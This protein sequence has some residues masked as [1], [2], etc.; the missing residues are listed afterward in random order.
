M[1][2]PWP[3]IARAAG[4]FAGTNVDDLVIL[5]ALFLTARTRGVPR[6]W[7]VVAG[8]YLGFLVLVAISAGAA[9][10]LVVVPGAWA[11]LL[12]LVPLGL[13]LYGLW[14]ARLADGDGSDPVAAGLFGV[15]TITIANGAD[16][17]SVYIPVF[18]AL[19]L[20]QVVQTTAVFLV[21]LALWCAAGAV[22]GRRPKIVAMVERAGHLMVPIVFIVIGIWI[23]VASGISAKV[24]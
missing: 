4:V 22:L 8:Q 23:L 21:L 2:V 15:A 3:T 9:A 5:T 24:L 11:G 17:L 7:Q 10:G 13:G 16:N 19:R 12:G 18:R 20:G 1:S 6:P 14:R